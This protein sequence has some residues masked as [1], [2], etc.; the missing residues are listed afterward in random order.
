M[1]TVLHLRKRLTTKKPTTTL[2]ALHLLGS[3]VN[4][5]DS[6]FHDILDSES[7][8]N[9]MMAT[10]RYYS[11]HKGADN[12][13]VLTLCLQLVQSWGEAFL[14]RRSQFPYLVDLY[15]TLRMEG[16]PFK[17]RARASDESRDGPVHRTERNA[18]TY[19]SKGGVAKN[20]AAIAAAL[21][22][23]IIESNSQNHKATHRRDVKQTKETHADI[24]RRVYGSDVTE[25]AFPDSSRPA[26]THH[27]TRSRE[28]SRAG[29]N[30]GSKNS[31][32]EASPWTGERPAGNP[33][34][35][36]PSSS[37]HAQNPP[38]L[39]QPYPPPQQRPFPPMREVSAPSS[40]GNALQYERPPPPSRE[41]SAPMP[42]TAAVA[43]RAEELYAE[44]RAAVEAAMA[45]RR[46][47]AGEAGVAT[48]AAGNFQQQYRQGYDWQEPEL[49]VPPHRQRR[50]SES[51][52]DVVQRLRTSMAIMRDMVIACSSQQELQQS[53]IGPEMLQ[54]ILSY[55][56]KMSD[57]VD[58]ALVNDPDV[59]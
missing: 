46:A 17:P 26:N 36:G 34:Q 14:P 32:R 24:L 22:Y 55:Q 16:M 11:K 15:S 9:D 13:E 48:G 20:D 43:S 45:A 53:D 3:L 42:S 1:E 7:F 31:S 54:E 50:V 30:N 41:M 21:Q 56:S 33:G 27:H 39:R 52:V 38:P 8:T 35:A 59:S 23:S 28:N 2:L 19:R 4:N 6:R 58:E 18:A 37:N 57:I 44:Q 47:A 29:S 10:A 51:A 49:E 5:C 25:S 40:T 12:K